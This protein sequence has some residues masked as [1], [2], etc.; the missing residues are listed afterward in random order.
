MRILALTR[1]GPLGPSSRVRFYQYYPYLRQHG[2][3]IQ[4]AALL[5]DEYIRRLYSKKRIA[6]SSII[7]AYFQ[8]LR[9][10]TR[11]SSFDLLWVEKEL[12]PWLPAWAE[13]MLQS[14]K[15]PYI[16]DFDDAVFHRYDMHANALVRSLLGK[17]I[18]AVMRHATSVVAGNDYLAIHAR[19]AGARQVQYLPSVID[20]LRYNLEQKENKEFRVGWIGSPITAPHLG[21]IKGALEQISKIIDV[22]LVLVGSG[23]NDLFPGIQKEI[24][25]WS[26][27]SEVPNIQS[28]DVGIMPLPDAPFERGKC[29]Y[30]LIQY[31]ACSLPVIASPVGVNSQIIEQ[32][33]TG[34]LASSAADWAQA[35]ETLYNDPRLRNEFG[36]AG[37]KKVEREYSLQVAAPR[38]LEIIT[39]AISN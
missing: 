31:M 25:P 37:R 2:I 5:D 1:Y 17:K 30:K 18:N 15:I 21:L 16:V 39:T 28:F 29:G 13:G 32:G 11:S 20:L 4:N 35:L 34:F 14:F 26:E 22:R 8:R 36:K 27:E 24:I 12:L 6:L 38:L 3:E 7:G 33:K 23:N 10:L 19:Q 9:W